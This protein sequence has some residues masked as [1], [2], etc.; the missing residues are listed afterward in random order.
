MDIRRK[1]SSSLFWALGNIALTVT[2]FV[3]LYTVRF[4]GIGIWLLK[5]VL[6]GLLGTIVFSIRDIFTKGTRMRA[7]FA[8]LL[9]LPVLAFFELLSVW[10]GPL[11]VSATGSTLPQFQIDGAAG[12]YGLQIYDP[13]SKA[14]SRDGDNGLIWS[15]AWQ[16]GRKF[17]PMRLRFAYGTAPAGYAQTAPTFAL[18]PTVTYRVT[19]QPAMGTDEY[20]TLRGGSIRKAGP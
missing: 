16:G 20:F 6:L 3:A 15:V 4:S 19:V 5:I 12:F 2:I 7:V 17:P 8:I 18:N 11:Y 14:E 10:E 1:V 9:C 13:G